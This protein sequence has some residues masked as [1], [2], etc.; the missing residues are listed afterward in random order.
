M[1]FTE[2]AELRQSCRSYD[3]TREVESEEIADI[4][5]PL[6]RLR[7]KEGGIFSEIRK[8]SP[9]QV[10]HFHREKKKGATEKENPRTFLYIIYRKS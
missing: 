2:I 4:P 1:N 3:P 9:T 10:R 6:G 7:P 5:L 8:G